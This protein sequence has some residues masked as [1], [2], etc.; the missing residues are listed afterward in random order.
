MRYFSWIIYSALELIDSLINFPLSFLGV[1]HFSTL[2]ENFFIH[3]EMNR[4][5]KESRKLNEDR[6]ER[7]KEAEKNLEELRYSLRN[8][9]DRMNKNE[10][11]TR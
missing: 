5:I 8:E 3:K 11:T 7:A 1:R 9:I 4:I 2:A 6:A 10:A